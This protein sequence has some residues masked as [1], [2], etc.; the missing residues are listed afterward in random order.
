MSSKKVLWTVTC[1]VAGLAVSGQAPGRALAALKT[2]YEPGTAHFA[3]GSSVTGRLPMRPWILSAPPIENKVR[4][5]ALFRPI[6]AY[7]AAATGHPVIYK[8]SDNWVSFA[9]NMTA[10][11]YDLVF[12]GPHFTAWSDHHLG[13]TPLVRLKGPLVFAVVARS[14][15]VRQVRDLVGE[16]VCANPPPNLGALTLMQDFPNALR[17]PYL[18]STTGSRA[19]YRGLL[20][21][22][23]QAAV[24]PLRAFRQYEKRTGAVAHIIGRSQSFPNETLSAG[25]RIS[26]ADKALIKAVLLAPSGQIATARLV[27]REGS[28]KWVPAQSQ[29]YAGLSR[30]LANA[31]YFQR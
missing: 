15:A 8:G 17:Q 13:A 28:S 11:K 26:P 10:G 29:T 2:A 27:R 4:E 18:I 14:L 12:S 25:A 24:L 22:R 3:P 31:L 20:A 7:L 23:C 5:A 30:L 6:A 9:S 21:G 16:P 1:L 19:A